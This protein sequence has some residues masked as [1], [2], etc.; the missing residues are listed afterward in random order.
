MTHAKGHPYE[1]SNSSNLKT[2]GFNKE[3]I[4]RI[5]NLLNSLGK[6]NGSCSFAQS[7]K[8]PNFYARSA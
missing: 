7:S 2:E 5:R 8:F 4:E 6:K 1:N 3:K